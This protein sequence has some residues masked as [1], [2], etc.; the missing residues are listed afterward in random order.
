MASQ[1]FASVVCVK[2]RGLGKA[3][4]GL[5]AGF[6]GSAAVK[7]V[8]SVKVSGV[9]GVPEYVSSKNSAVASPGLRM[10]LGFSGL[11]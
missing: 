1:L 4:C 8:V 11:R 7:R 10:R 6:C 9:A 2:M 5:G 3:A